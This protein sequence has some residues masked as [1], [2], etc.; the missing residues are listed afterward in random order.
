MGVR[1]A[2]SGAFGVAAGV[3]DAAAAFVLDGTAAVGAGS[4][5][6]VVAVEV[7]AL[8]QHV[9]LDRL[10]DGV[11]AGGDA[12]LAEARGL[13]AGDADELFHCLAGLYAA[14]P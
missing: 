2:P 8:G 6:V 4:A 3:A 10:G 7:L 12:V 1:D 14:P 9:H 11:G 13:V 5:A